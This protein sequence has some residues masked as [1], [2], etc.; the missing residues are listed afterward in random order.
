M[1]IVEQPLDRTNFHD[2]ALNVS[3]HNHVGDGGN[4]HLALFG[5]HMIDVVGAGSADVGQLSIGFAGIRILHLKALQ[6]LNEVFSGS[7]GYICPV[8]VQNPVTQGLGGFDA[9]NP[10]EL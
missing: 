10:F 1:R 3:L 2:T 9:V 4:K 6:V 7:E 5:F 8:D